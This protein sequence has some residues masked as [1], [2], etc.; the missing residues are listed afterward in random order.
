M[1]L[2]FGWLTGKSETGEDA[3]NPTRR[4]FFVGAAALAAAGAAV[5]VGATKAQAYHYGHPHGPPSHSK[6]R[7]REWRE[8]QYYDDYHSPKRSAYRRRK[9][10]H[11]K[12]GSWQQHPR[13]M[14]LG[15]FGVCEY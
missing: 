5:A 8:E 14:H 9:Y 6:W 3:P 7:S 1:K 4:A 12:Y 2:N 10:Y 11:R 15:P 13:C